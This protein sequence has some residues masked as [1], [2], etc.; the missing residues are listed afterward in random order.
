MA[1]PGIHKVQVHQEP[2]LTDN[3]VAAVEVVVVT[4]GCRTDKILVVQMDNKDY[5]KMEA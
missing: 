2:F 5:R 3:F 4:F 1:F